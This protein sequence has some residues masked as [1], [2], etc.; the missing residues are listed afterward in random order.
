M[1]ERFNTGDAKIIDHY[2]YGIV[3]DG[4]LMEGITSE[5]ASFAGHLGLANIIYIYDCNQITIEGSTSLAFTEDVAKRF[6]AYNWRV[7]K[8]DGHNHTEIA[9]TIEAARDETK[10]LRSSL[11]EPT[12]VRAVQINRIRPPF[13]ENRWGR[14]ELELTKE[15]LGW[16]KD[17]TFIS[18]MKLNSFAMAV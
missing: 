10:D 15:S 9:E 4:D 17:K 13:T 1:A 7:F 12:L 16:P 3:S 5:A 2:I 14:K 6:E 11:P 8:I 18:R